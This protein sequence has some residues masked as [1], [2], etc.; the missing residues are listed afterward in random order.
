MGN[1][2]LALAAKDLRVKVQ[3]AVDGGEGNGD[4]AGVVKGVAGEEVIQ[5]AAWVVVGHQPE[6]RA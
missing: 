5:G 3:Q 4:E 6:L 1:G 2:R